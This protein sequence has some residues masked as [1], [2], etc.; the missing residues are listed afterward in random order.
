[1]LVKD[2]NRPTLNAEQFYIPELI[3]MSVQLKVIPLQ[4]ESS[5]CNAISLGLNG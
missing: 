1:M 2:D 5:C 4:V 3:G